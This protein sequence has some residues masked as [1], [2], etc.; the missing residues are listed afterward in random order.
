MAL[1]VYTHDV[2]WLHDSGH[3]HPERPARLDA[4]LKG[5]AASGRQS[6]R[7]EAPLVERVAL[8]RVHTPSYIA[9]IEEFCLRGGGALDPDTHAG[10]ESW[11]AALRSAGAGL[12]AMAALREEEGD[13]AF[14][15]VR[16]P[17]HHALAARAMGFCLFNN[18]AVAAA[19]A[20]ARGERVAIVDW[21]VHHGNGTQDMFFDEPAVLYVSAHEYPQYP[22]TGRLDEI[23][24]GGAVGTTINLPVPTGT[25]GDVYRAAFERL[26]VPA[27]TQFNPDWIFVSAGY[28]A[29]AADPLAGLRLV[30]DDYAYMSGA[31]AGAIPA[32]RIVFYL[33]GGYDLR[34][35]SE[36]VA[37]TVDGLSGS[38]GVAPSGGS[39]PKAAWR[40]LMDAKRL[41]SR[42][43]DL[44]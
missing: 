1:L 15:A 16:P 38:G 42:Y 3:Q 17:G 33:E 11:E 37:A 22:G 19:D 21:D 4:A 26:I 34:A 6:V 31:L 5:I 20:V 27:V 43:W 40:V 24:S 9:R 12:A 35:I 39:S 18:I 36:S 7:I 29:H 10:E 2:C 32:S 8:Q 30:P 44:D 14:I 28:D 41:A 13:A 23:G 25:Q